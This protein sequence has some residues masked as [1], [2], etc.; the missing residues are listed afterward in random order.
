MYEAK[1]T[2]LLLV[3]VGFVFGEASGEE[4]VG[5]CLI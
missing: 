2:V 1:W 3:V 4:E 5:V